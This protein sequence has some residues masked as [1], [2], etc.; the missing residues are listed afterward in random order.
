MSNKRGIQKEQ[1]IA[2]ETALMDLFEGRTLAVI[3]K[4]ENDGFKIVNKNTSHSKDEKL[5][6]V[7]KAHGSLGY[8]FG[9]EPTFKSEMRE[10]V[11]FVNYVRSLEQEMGVTAV[12][13]IL[14]EGCFSANEYYNQKGSNLYYV[15]SPARLLSTLLPEVDVIG[16]MGV[17]NGV[18]V[19]AWKKKGNSTEDALFSYREGAVVFKNGLAID[20]E[21]KHKDPNMWCDHDYS[22]DFIILPCN[23]NEQQ[24]YNVSQA[25]VD[26]NKLQSN[27]VETKEFVDFEHTLGQ[28]QLRESRL[29]K[30]S[31]NRYGLFNKGSVRAVMND[32]LAY[33]CRC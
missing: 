16:F 13:Q 30:H 2:S 3:Q 8:F 10:L 15:N 17:N 1:S 25:I 27:L 22:P 4:V 29:D 23:I 6:L 28:R 31:D 26:V 11:A 21:T 24:L 20:H 14:L 33:G 7:V 32:D 9:T 12:N 5:T 19:K 18:G